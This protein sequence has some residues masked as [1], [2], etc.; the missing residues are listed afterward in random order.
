MKKILI[1]SAIAA[2]AALFACSCDKALNSESQSSFDAATIYSNADLAEGVI[3]GIT[4]VMAETNCYRGRYLP[5]IGLNSDIEWY[6]S[7][8]PTNSKFQIAGYTLKPNNDQLNLSNG[9]FPMMYMGIERANLAIEGIRQ[10]GDPANNADMAYILAEALTLRALLYYDLT[11]AWGDVPARFDPIT[12]ETIYVAKSSRDVIYKQLLADLEEAIPNL[13]YPGATAKTSRTDRVNKTF[14]AGL[15]AR[16]A[17]MASGYA[18]RPADGTVGT[19]DLG[20]VRLSS[21]PDL[22]KSVLYPKALGYLVD[23]I[24]S[25][26]STLEDFETY[27]KNQSNLSNMVAG[28]ANETLYVIPFSAG[29][30]RWNY[31]FAVRSEGSS[32][33]GGLTV[34]RGGD[35]GPVPTMWFNYDPDD[36]RRDVTCVNWRWNADDEQELAGIQRWYFGK[37]R[38]EWMK[39]APYKGGNDDGVK[40]VVLRYADILLMAAEIANEL[41]K[42]DDAK[43]YLDL[44]RRRAFKGHEDK[45]DAYVAAI[46]DKEAMFNAI[47]DERAFEFC[48]EMTRRFDLI[49]WNLLEDK[50]LDAIDDLKDLRDLTGKYAGVNGLN[51]DVYYQVNDSQITV[52]GFNGETVAPTGPWEKKGGYFTKVVDSQ[53]KDT[54][55]YEDLVEH[56]LFDGDVED[57][58]YHMFWPIFNDTMSNSQGHIKNDYGYDSI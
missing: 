16:I 47:V 35:A 30:G 49:R 50:M 25:G 37:Y 40:P 56:G 5:W 22:Q 11:R 6:N 54:G 38:Y 26:T 53:G 34:T 21:D 14:A 2:I 9:P 51:G 4:E 27:W 44:V 45:A 28:P 13:P 15:Y 52:Y 55:L 7:Y 18:I 32:Y 17:L 36:V 46:G 23:A 39:T 57:L 19:G 12:S 42:L 1:Y 20:E 58:K 24:E 29:R 43:D 48:G 8:N 31:T 10:Y 33:A 41:G 3:F